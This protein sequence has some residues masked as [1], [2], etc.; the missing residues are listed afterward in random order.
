MKLKATLSL[1]VLTYCKGLDVSTSVFI[2]YLRIQVG[3][4]HGAQSLRLRL[5]MT[6]GYTSH[7]G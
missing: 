7:P 6:I 5:I 2:D 3:Y 4:G 1:G